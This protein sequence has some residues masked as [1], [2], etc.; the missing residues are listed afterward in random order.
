MNWTGSYSLQFPTQFYQYA[1]IL[2]WRVGSSLF[3]TPNQ[4][5]A[6]LL[7][8]QEAV[9][10]MQYRQLVAK[11]KQLNSFAHVLYGNDFRLSSE[12][13]QDPLTTFW[14]SPYPSK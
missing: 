13:L 9:F 8:Y 3:F 6:S 5:L 11:L 2:T 10:L 12:S 1:Y 7:S 14:T 4:S